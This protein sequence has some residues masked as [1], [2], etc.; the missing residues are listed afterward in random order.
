MLSLAA[1]SGAPGNGDESD[2]DDK[3]SP[4]NS[5][6][7]ATTTEPAPSANAGS[8]GY[9]ASASCDRL[10]ELRNANLA[11]ADQKAVQISPDDLPFST[12]AVGSI[13]CVMTYSTTDEPE[14]ELG[15]EVIA[16]DTRGNG[17]FVFASSPELSVTTCATSTPLMC[18]S[19]P[20]DIYV[21][22]SVTSGLDDFPSSQLV[23]AMVTSR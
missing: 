18:F 3:A 22:V 7:G 14:Q 16:D 11:P 15:I 19:G 5:A 9:S 6:E 2:L 17:P 21:S 12:P 4:S 13:Y 8:G 1:C 23:A 10:T 20:D